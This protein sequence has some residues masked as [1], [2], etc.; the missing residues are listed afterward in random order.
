MLGLFCTSDRRN[1]QRST[2]SL[3]KI[4]RIM[5]M[6]YYP[7]STAPNT[8]TPNNKL[9]YEIDRNIVLGQAGASSSGL[10]NIHFRNENITV[11]AA[12]NI[13]N[14]ILPLVA[15]P[16]PPYYQDDMAEAVPGN[17]LT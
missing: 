8:T 6:T 1:T 16:C 13:E 10:I 7:G 12:S 4:Y 9:Y 17:I 5:A 3:N 2:P 11:F 15:L 14:K